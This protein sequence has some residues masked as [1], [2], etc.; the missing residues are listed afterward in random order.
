MQRRH[1]QLVGQ[2]KG[3]HHSGQLAGLVGSRRTVETVDRIE[4]DMPGSPCWGQ[5]GAVTG[6]KA[7]CE[8]LN[9]SGTE[10]PVG[11]GLPVR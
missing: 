5:R 8:H 4:A 3:I 10:S 7:G 11:A 9:L 2:A 1:T 6:I